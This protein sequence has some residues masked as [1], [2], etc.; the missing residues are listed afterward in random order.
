[1]GLEAADAAVGGGGDGDRR[2]AEVRVGGPR[3]RAQPDRKPAGPAPG[4]RV[5]QALDHHLAADRAGAFARG[6]QERRQPAGLDFRVGVGGGHEAGGLAGAQKALAGQVHAQPPRG[7]DAERRALDDT[8]AQ[9]ARGLQGALARG[10]ATAVEDQDDLVGVARDAVLRGERAH[11]APDEL[12]LVARRHAD[13][14]PQRAHGP[15]SRRRRA[16][17]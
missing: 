10:V 3:E 4:G 6:L 12:L 16:A 7:P 2:A 11:A 13:D 14:R 1:V 9:I 8:Q 5:A 15:S 17:S